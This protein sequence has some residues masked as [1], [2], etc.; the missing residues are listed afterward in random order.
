MTQNAI[1]IGRDTLVA[2][3][4]IAWA[5]GKIDPP[6]AE[7]LRATAARLQLGAD[8][9][10]AV[11]ASI[12]R[13]VTLSE[14]ETIRMTRLTRLFTYAAA[15]WIAKLGGG[16]AGP[17]EQAAL[18]ALGDRLGLSAVARTRAA[19]AADAIGIAAGDDPKSYDLDLLRSRLSASL[20]QVGDD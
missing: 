13:Q 12:A 10:Q 19:K 1:E 6:E 5:D 4:A 20:S 7:G 3:A 17:A 14:L 2:L 16:A 9:L 11:E 8:D 18:D 15:T